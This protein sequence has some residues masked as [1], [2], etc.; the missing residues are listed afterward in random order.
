M[1]LRVQ[2]FVRAFAGVS[3]KF[4]GTIGGSPLYQTLDDLAS[5]AIAFTQ[6]TGADQVQ[7]VYQQTITI[8]AG[9]SAALDLAGLTDAFGQPLT[10]AT[11]KLLHLEAAAENTNAVVVGGAATNTF[12]GPFGAAAHTI[13]VPPGCALH[14]DHRAASGWTVSAGTGAVLQIANGGSGSSVTCN[15]TLAGD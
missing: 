5:H 10:F 1:S 8:A 4:G 3:G 9:G 2:G 11:V 14:I 15:L 6:G 12:L 13:A 7:Q